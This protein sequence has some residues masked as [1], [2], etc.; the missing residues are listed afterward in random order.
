MCMC[1]LCVCAYCA[2]DNEI[3]APV[4]MKGEER[5]ESTHKLPPFLEGSQALV[6]YGKGEPLLSVLHRHLV[7]I[8]PHTTL[9]TMGLWCPCTLLCIIYRSLL[10]TFEIILW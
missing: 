4:Q 10:C 2:I 6:V 5:H 3:R 8:C 7:Y 1:V 9:C